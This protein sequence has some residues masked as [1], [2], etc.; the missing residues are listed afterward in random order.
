M[1]AATPTSCWGCFRWRQLHQEGGSQASTLSCRGGPE[2]RE[3]VPV[4]ETP[5]P[6]N[7]AHRLSFPSG[8]ERHL[9]RL[10]SSSAGDN[11]KS[12]PPCQASDTD[13]GLGRTITA[14]TSE[15]SFA[16]VMAPP[17]RPGALAASSADDDGGLAHEMAL[18]RVELEIVRWECESI[19]RQKRRRDQDLVG[20]WSRRRRVLDWMQR[21]DSSDTSYDPSTLSSTSEARAASPSPTSSVEAL[22][23]TPPSYVASPRSQSMN[24]SPAPSPE[25]KRCSS[26]SPVRRKMAESPVSPMRTYRLC[27][28]IGEAPVGFRPRCSSNPV[29]GAPRPQPLASSRTATQLSRHPDQGTSCF[30]TQSIPSGRAPSP[31]SVQEDRPRRWF[32]GLLQDPEPSHVC[33]FSSPQ[34][35]SPRLQPVMEAEC[36]GG[37]D[38]DVELVSAGYEFPRDDI[39]KARRQARK[40]RAKEIARTR[41]DTTTST[42]S[43]A[44]LK[45]HVSCH[46]CRRKVPKVARPRRGQDFRL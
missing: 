19:I 13:S 35:Q 15:E 25:R 30:P 17:R 44:T 33:S 11:R 40:E 10:H 31:L 32:E 34:R 20:S 21:H 42:D 23:R 4:T 18:L 3:F 39:R 26:A 29:P 9:A 8:I 16:G 27:C 12:F 43:D 41:A 37:L 5:G 6:S 24:L 1:A 36:F 46:A 38:L 22:C 2:C 28:T 14:E 45:H 7:A